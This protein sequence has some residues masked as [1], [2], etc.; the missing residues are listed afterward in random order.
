[1]ASPGQLGLVRSACIERR[2]RALSGDLPRYR[3]ALCTLELAGHVA[4]EG[5]AERALF[6]LLDT[7]LERLADRASDAE[8]CLAIFELRLLDLLGLRP[9]LDHCAACGRRPRGE[10]GSVAFAPGAGGRLCAR[11]A[12]EARASGRTVGSLPL[13]VVRVAASL[14][15]APDPGSANIRV[16]RGLRTALTAFVRRFLEYHLETRPRAS[17]PR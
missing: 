3:A 8:L 10:R 6:D 15:E 11:C 2:R 16:E 17:L 4:R 5:T 12:A 7:T 1:M 9:A 13:N 14:V